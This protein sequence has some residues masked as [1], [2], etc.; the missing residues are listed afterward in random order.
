[1][2]KEKNARLMAKFSWVTVHAEVEHRET[3]PISVLG[4]E[5]VITTMKAKLSMLK[6]INAFQLNGYSFLSL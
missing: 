2:P 4:D 3:I 5:L 1:M 6:I